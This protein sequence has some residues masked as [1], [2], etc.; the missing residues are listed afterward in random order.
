[1]GITTGEATCGVV[2]AERR[3]EYTIIGDIVNLSARLEA[4]TKE[5]GVPLLVSE[6]TALL[7]DDNVRKESP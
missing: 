3:L 1:M 5:Y 7:L 2:G 4:T 6:P